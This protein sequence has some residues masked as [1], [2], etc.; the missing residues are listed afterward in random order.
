[1]PV[2]SHIPPTMHLL[3]FLLLLPSTVLSSL[4][5]TVIL[6]GKQLVLMVISFPVV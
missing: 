1:M 3:L 2:V 6:S 5:A 4:S